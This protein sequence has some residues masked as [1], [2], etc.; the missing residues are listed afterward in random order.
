LPTLSSG[1]V[2][3]LA[4]VSAAKVT[5]NSMSERMAAS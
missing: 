2:V 1:E 5:R 3:Q 4:E